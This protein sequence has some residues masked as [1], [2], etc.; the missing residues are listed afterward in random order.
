MPMS[1]NVIDWCVI[2]HLLTVCVYASAQT[3]CCSVLQQFS[4]TL[5]S[6]RVT[7][8]SVS[9]SVQTGPVIAQVTRTHEKVLSATPASLFG[10]EETLSWISFCTFNIYNGMPF[11]AVDLHHIFLKIKFEM[12]LTCGFNR[13]IHHRCGSF[14]VSL[15]KLLKINIPLYGVFR[16][17][18]N[19]R[20]PN[21]AL[22]W[23]Q[24]NKSLVL[25][26]KRPHG[27][28]FTVLHM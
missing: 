22:Y 12:T 8:P 21:A 28:Y 16:W 11:S 5:L 10:H 18:F 25:E 2:P 9:T 13:R 14:L 17:R 3:L 6:V 26:L 23:G 27:P 19:L 24:V 7:T 4:L 1:F 20:S 15:E